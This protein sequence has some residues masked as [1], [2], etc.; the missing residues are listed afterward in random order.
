M[1]SSLTD[2]KKMSSHPADTLMMLKNILLEE[3]I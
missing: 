3:V 1:L 2:E